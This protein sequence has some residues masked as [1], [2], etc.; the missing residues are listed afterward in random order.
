MCSSKIA[1]VFVA[2]I[3]LSTAIP[4][5]GEGGLG[6]LLGGNLGN[7]GIGGV[8]EVG[9]VGGILGDDGILGGLLGGDQNAV[10]GLLTILDLP[11]ND[12]QL[13][14][15]GNNSQITT[16]LNNFVSQISDQDLQKVQEILSS[17]TANTPIEQVV[18]Q[19]N[20]VNPSLGDA[21]NQLVAGVSELL[22]SLFEQASEI[23]RSLAD[24]L[25]QLKNIV[26]SNQTNEEKEQAINQLKENNEIQFNTILFIITQLLNNLGGIGVPEL[27]VSTPQVPI[28]V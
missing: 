3:A 6:G 22:R 2:S 24:V 1:L 21:L 23:I 10:N 27:P 19:L 15:L 9:G 12:L 13:P 11:S 25:Q 18:S 28:N 7:P 16:L 26:E 14:L 17:V 5:L 4:I 20:A 8:P